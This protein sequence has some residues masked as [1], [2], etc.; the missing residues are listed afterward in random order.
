VLSAENSCCRPARRGARGSRELTPW[1]GYLARRVAGL[2]GRGVDPFP[3]VERLLGESLDLVSHRLDAWIT[4]LASARLAAMRGRRVRGVTV[5]AYGWVVDLSPRGAEPRSDGSI[6]APSLPQATTAAILRS[7][8]LARSDPGAYAV[9][10]SSRRMRAAMAV[11]D[12]V[13]AG[14][15]IGALL[16]YSVERRLH[17]SE[18]ALDH[19]VAPLRRLAPLVGVQH[20]GDGAPGF[21]AARDVVDGARL[22]ELGLPAV[23]ADAGVLAALRTAAERPA[24]EAVLAALADDVDGVADLLLAESVHQLACGNPERAGATIEALASGGRPP[25]RPQVLDTPRLARP[26]T[27]RVLVAVPP[28]LTPEA[29][30]AA[31]ARRS[32]P[33][34][35]ARPRLDA[36]ASRLLGAVDRIRVPVAWTSPDGVVVARRDGP[37]PLD[38]ECALDVVALA[39][40]GTLTDAAAQALVARRPD[41]VPANAVPVITRERPGGWARRDVSAGEV[42]GLAVAIAAVLAVARPAVAADLGPADVPPSGE[43][44]GPDGADGPAEVSVVPA[45]AGAVTASL[46]DA[47]DRGEGDDPVRDWLDRAATVRPGAAALADLLLRA[48]AAGTGRGLTLRAG[49]TPFVPGDRWVGT[50]GAPDGATGLVVHGAAEPDLTAGVAALVVDAWSEQIPDEFQPAA[51][52]LHF[53]A[54]G[55][56]PPQAV[57]LAVPP[58][59]GAPW[60]VDALATVLRET[61]D[62]ARLRLVDLESLAWLGRYLPAAYLPEGALGTPRL[63]VED[64]PVALDPSRLAQF[65]RKES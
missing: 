6:L 41:G 14:Q 18:P 39:A 57:L 52:A 54:P 56:R 45:D 34:A 61:L 4:S 64:L 53:D 31:D 26:L 17:E 21:V 37:W 9:D 36:W 22:A 43:P 38:A 28:G 20:P 5:G 59:P 51:V 3:A 10:L 44:A 29:G 60:T 8:A 42:F 12:G 7:G 23:L 25:P 65:I 2:H 55:A 11:L 46:G 33:A 50:S 13:R 32:R 19:L 30:W 48:D 24:L 35:L 15:P 16:G 49:Q 40:A 62:L 27:H 58:V 63:H 1:L 47:L